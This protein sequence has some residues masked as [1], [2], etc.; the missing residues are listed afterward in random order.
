MGSGAL[1]DRALE[2]D[3]ADLLAHD[4]RLE[5]VDV[6]VRV[7]GAV[8]HLGG[9]VATAEE[10]RLLRELVGRLRRV[11]AVWDLVRLPHQSALQVVDIG[12]GATRQYPQA[13]GIDQIPSPVTGVVADLEASL[14]LASDS[15]DHLF[16]VHVLEH[17]H[18]PLRL[19]NEV[20]RV[21]RPDGVAHVMVPHWRHPN[22]V[23]DPTHIRYFGLETFRYFCQDRPGVS[24]FW[25]LAL[26]VSHD[27]VI[28]DLGPVGDGR[29]P[30]PEVMARFF[31]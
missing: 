1:L 6:E 22:A 10:R 23:A 17:V 16:A 9:T 29:P 30:G 7:D 31:G 11:Q 18:E 25:P 20:H 2:D 19:M 24:C 26:S 8:V 4:R 3:V 15:V 28:A 12:C 13:V 14:P 27:T 21:L 5:H